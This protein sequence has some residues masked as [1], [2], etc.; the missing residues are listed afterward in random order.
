MIKAKD[1][2]VEESPKCT[3][4]SVPRAKLRLVFQGDECEITLG[5]SNTKFR[6]EGTLEFDV[7]GDLLLS[8]RGEMGLYSQKILAA[9]AKMIHLNSQMSPQI[10]GKMAKQ[11]RRKYGL[12]HPNK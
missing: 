9:D 2:S 6:H 4:I 1:V 11:I 10:R 12:R 7:Q 5:H 8:A 3:V